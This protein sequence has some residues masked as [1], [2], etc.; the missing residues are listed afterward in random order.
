MSMPGPSIPPQL[1]EVREATALVAGHLGDLSRT[2]ARTLGEMEELRH[3][4]TALQR[5]LVD[6]GPYT[7]AAEPSYAELGSPLRHLQEAGRL[8]ETVA[9]P[10]RLNAEAL[11]TTLEKAGLR[12]AALAGTPGPSGPLGS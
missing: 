2:L 12:L 6:L 1:S 11:R 3:R 9:E 8:L 5:A 4:A 7:P 10:L